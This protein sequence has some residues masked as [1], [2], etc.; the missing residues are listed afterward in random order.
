MP[1]LEALLQDWQRS[2][3]VA[4]GGSAEIV[5]E[6]ESHL[7]EEIV[8]LT[9]AGQ[10]P[11]AAFACAQA[12]LGRPADLAAEYARVAAP[13]GWLPIPIGLGLFV[14]LLGFFA[15]VFFLPKLL[16]GGY[17][18]LVAHVAALVAGYAVAFYAGLLG[19][20][21]VACW[22]VRPIGLGQRRALGR[23]LFLANASA[24][25]LLASGV[26]LGMVWAQHQWGRSWNNDP[27]EVG[28]LIAVL[29]FAGMAVLTRLVPRRQHLW[30]L[31][32]IAGISVGVWGWF[33]PRLFRQLHAYDTNWSLLYLL[34][35]GGTA[36][37]LVVALL[38]MLPPGRLNRQSA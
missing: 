2:L 36:V 18:V 27:A 26:L 37:P 33:G 22:L 11:G 28:T 31:L 25:L 20:C 3:T 23:A 32:A 8:R 10:E 21:Y 30:V 29:W 1:D 4:F 15:W 24:A 38:G 35:I 16:V 13:V 9:Q 17:A 7:R 19:I 34:L 5:E 14:L 12:K 6:L